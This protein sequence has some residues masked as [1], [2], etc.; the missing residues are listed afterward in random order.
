MVQW[1]TE[2]W[3]AIAGIF[4]AGIAFAKAIVKLTPTKTDDAIVERIEGLEK[5]LESIFAKDPSKAPTE[6]LP[7]LIK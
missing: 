3:M 4:V 6:A 1:I 5:T 7:K 2:N